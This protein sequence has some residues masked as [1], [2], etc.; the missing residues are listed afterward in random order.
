MLS[1]TSYNGFNLFIY[2]L[3]QQR[4]K[5][6]LSYVS[7]S[8]EVKA[9]NLIFLSGQSREDDNAHVWIAALTG[10]NLADYLKAINAWHHKVEQ[11]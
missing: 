8:T 6:G 2:R 4:Q 5:Y 10:T 1:L 7:V 9:L 3:K 11:E